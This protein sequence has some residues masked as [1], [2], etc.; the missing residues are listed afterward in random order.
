MQNC[1]FVCI[2]LDYLIFIYFQGNIPAY[3]VIRYY[4]DN[5]PQALLHLFPDIGLE[6]SYSNSDYLESDPGMSLG[7]HGD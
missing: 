2:L 6:S 5:L 3:D 7:Y 1:V 4:G